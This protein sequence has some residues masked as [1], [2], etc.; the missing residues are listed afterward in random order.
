M[1]DWNAISIDLMQGLS[2]L[3]ELEIKN[4]GGIQ[5]VIKLEGLLTITGE[6]QDLLLPRFKK[7]LLID[8]HE[9]RCIWKGATKLIN[10]NI[11][12]DLKVIRCKKLTHLFT[13]ALAQSLQ[14]LK[15]L[16]IGSCDELE[17]L[18][19]E[20]VEEQVFPKSHPQPLCFP[21]PCLVKI[22]VYGC[23]KLK[24]LF[25]VDRWIPVSIILT[26]EELEIGNCG[27]L[28]GV[29][30]FEGLLT[31]E[32]EQQDEFFPRLRK[33]CLV[34]LHELMY[35]WKGPIQLVNLN[36]LE[37]LEVIEC[38]K[39]THLFTPALAQSLQRLK[40]LEI[41]RCDELEH[42]IVENAEEQVLSK[43]HLQSLCFPK[44]CLT[45]IWV[46]GCNKL[47]CL[48][49]VDRWIPVSII[50]TLEQLEIDNCGGLQE[51]FNF[52]GLLTR[53][54]EQQDE[55]FPRLSKMCLVN[56][57]ELMYIWKG[58]IQL[59]NVN[60]LEDLKVIRCKKLTHLFTPALAQSLQKLKFLEI[61]RCDELEHL[62]VENVEEQVSS[63]SHLQPLCFPKLKIVN[64]GY[65]NK[66]KYLFPMTIADSLLELKLLAVK[67]N[68]Q[69]MEV[70][71]YEGDAGVQKVV[72]LPQLE[73][74]GL[75]GLPSLVNFCPKN[76]QFTLP[77]LWE[78]R[79][80]SCKNMRTTFTRTPDRS[81]LINGEVIQYSFFF[82][83]FLIICSLN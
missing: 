19:V 37:D 67:E 30:S 29:F 9:L 73:F 61:R 70:F 10:L 35:I 78:L 83:F 4:C 23:N 20:N 6:Q 25:N 77:K 49:H 80:E 82:F 52:E 81:V 13:L 34:E 65:C 5:E 74:M 14:K 79:V 31:R 51:V 26:L 50:F 3:E 33:I 2:N 43:S 53:E 58:P 62:I 41:K 75:K 48:F 44:P 24:C 7:M 54:G 18:I 60:N 36:N 21:K 8:L 45:K 56:L 17:H 39:L 22:W 57:H 40:F 15:F 46:N 59:V 76:Y 72:T 16:E 68:S 1:D 38:K 71:T 66:L 28:Q 64:V 63:E 42:L 55:F 27:G 12:E 69:L 11:L 32:G 47:K